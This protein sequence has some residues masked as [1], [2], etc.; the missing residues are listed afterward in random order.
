[1]SANLLKYT[2]PYYKK[3]NVFLNIV[4]AN[5]KEIDRIDS[6][7]YDNFLQRF[8]ATATAEGLQKYEYDFALP[9]NP[10]GKSLDERRGMVKGKIKGMQT[11]TPFW[12]KNIVD[13]I[14]GG[15]CEVIN[16]YADYSMS[17]RFNG[18][19]KQ[20]NEVVT[21]IEDIKPAHYR[22]IVVLNTHEDLAGEGYAP[23]IAGKFT[24]ANLSN[25]NHAKLRTMNLETEL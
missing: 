10:T 6:V 14:T 19:T 4:A 21:L 11:I 25:H 24:H 17:I 3:N 18:Y 13:T 7:M 2:P 8:T 12:L 1:M 16:N 23:Y 9:I 20:V 15:N 22:L 5:N